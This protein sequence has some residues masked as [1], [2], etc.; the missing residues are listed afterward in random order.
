MD[1]LC[2]FVMKTII[3][4][5][6]ALLVGVLLA[7]TSVLTTFFTDNNLLLLTQKSYILPTFFVLVLLTLKGLYEISQYTD[8]YIPL[9]LG[10]LALVLS[11]IGLLVFFRVLM[12]GM[13]ILVVAA[14]WS[15]GIVRSYYPRKEST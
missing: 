9:K 15:R 14:I 4:A 11:I 12:L 8:E 1:E 6:L 2:S 5:I 10:V 7:E 3:Y 13:I